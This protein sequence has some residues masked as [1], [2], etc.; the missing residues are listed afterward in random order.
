ML[1]SLNIIPLDS[2]FSETKYLATFKD[3]HFVVSEPLAQFI[4]IIKK[5]E[6]FD[7]AASEWSALKGKEYSANDVKAIY[8]VYLLPA[9]SSSQEKKGP[10]LWKT[11][12]ISKEVVDILQRRFRILFRPVIMAVVLTVTAALEIWFLT[13]GQTISVGN[14]DILSFSVILAS[15]LAA[16]FFHEIGHASACCYFGEKAQS[17]GLGLYLNFPVFYT[18]VS[19]IWKLPRKKR[20]VVNFAGIYF[21]MIFLLPWFVFYFATGNGIAKFMIYMTNLNFV[22]TLNPFF[23]FDGYWIMSDLTGIPN[24]RDKSNWLVRSLK[25]K[26]MKKQNN[27]SFWSQIRPKERVLMIIYTVGVNLFFAYYIL[28]VIPKF[29]KSCICELPF[30]IKALV[31]DIA[32]GNSVSFGQVSSVVSQLLILAMTIYFLYNIIRRIFVRA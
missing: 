32:V 18:D 10:F 23:K 9:I 15:M 30:S 16:S 7:D 19:G 28:F 27:N 29:L 6:T 8:D 26:I 13:Q 25:D 5:S 20:M 22:F 1:E 2:A 4:S 24:L 12:I 21:Q 31:L 17:I 3:R 14:V 11:E